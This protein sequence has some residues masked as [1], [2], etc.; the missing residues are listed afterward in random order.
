MFAKRTIGSAPPVSG[1]A[2]VD[3]RTKRLVGRLLPGQ[4]AVIDHADLDRVA[5]SALIEKRPVAVINASPSITGRYPSVGAFSLIEAGIVVVDDLGSSVLQIDEGTR[6]RVEDNRVFIGEQLVAEGIRQTRATVEA[7]IEEAK[8]GL[9]AQLQAFAE[10]TLIYVRE[11][12]HLLF[13]PPNP[14]QLAVDFHGRHVMVVVRGHDYHADLLHLRS[15]VRDMRP[16]IVAVDGGADACLQEGLTP[17]VVIGDFDSVSDDA[18][19]CGAQLVVHAYVGG[20]APGAERLDALGL[21]YVKYEAPGMSEDVA[22]LLAYDE[23]AELIVAVGTHASM[24]EFL[25]KGRAGMA[26]TFLTRLKVGPVL[27]DAKGVSRLYR[28]T[29]RTSDLAL[30][31]AAAIIALATMALVSYPF[32]TFVSGAWFLLGQFFAGVWQTLTPW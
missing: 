13:D 6:L 21:P 29:V 3:R 1:P 27:V 23:G 15:Y 30:L 5:A 17:D 11:E 2:C 31:L 24:V 28:G 9:S 19:R 7:T 8:A 14:P 32:R 26:S 25:E 18:L 16:V 20:S 12:S 22:M 10:N 4:I